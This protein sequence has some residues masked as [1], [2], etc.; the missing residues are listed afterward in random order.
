MKKERQQKY[1]IYNH[2]ILWRV[3]ELNLYMA[4]SS[5]K[6]AKFYALGAMLLYFFAFEGYLNWLGNRIAPEAWE[7]EREFFSRPPYQGGLGKYRFLTKVVRLS[8]PGASQGPFQTAKELLKL[9][10]MAVHPRAEAGDRLVKFANSHFPPH[11]RG[12]LAEKVSPKKA[13]RARD[14]LSKLAEDLHIGAKSSYPELLWEDQA[15]GLSLRCSIT[16]MYKKIHD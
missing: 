15:F 1:E 6:N 5:Q 3:A 8:A 9:R 13:S 2:R 4:T 10:D 11:Y 16:P 14:H 12:R 7:E